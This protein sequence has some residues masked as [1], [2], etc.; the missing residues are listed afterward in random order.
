MRFSLE[1][2]LTIGINAYLGFDGFMHVAET[3]IV[4]SP[5]KTRNCMQPISNNN[6]NSPD[7]W[8]RKQP[9][10]GGEE[11]VSGSKEPRTLLSLSLR[12]AI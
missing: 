6:I 8:I 1:T 10:S 3:T 4:N 9:D 2:H 7:N 5:R 12:L 11:N